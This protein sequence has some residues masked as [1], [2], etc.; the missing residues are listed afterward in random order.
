MRISLNRAEPRSVVPA[1]DGRSPTVAGTTLRARSSFRSSL[2]VVPL[3]LAQYSLQN[4]ASHRFR[5]V[6]QD[7]PLAASDSLESRDYST[8]NI[9]RF[10]KQSFRTDPERIAAVQGAVHHQRLPCFGM[11]RNADHL[12]LVSFV[13]PVPSRLDHGARPFRT[14]E[15]WHRRWGANQG[16]R[17]TVAPGRSLP[18]LPNACNPLSCSFGWPA[19]Q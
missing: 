19:C 17:A 3:R 5:A 8:A 9:H 14:P 16:T 6:F 18:A 12:V 10:F 15:F 13:V 1:A 7:H 11:E 4:F 2:T